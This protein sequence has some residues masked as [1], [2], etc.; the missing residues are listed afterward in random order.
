MKNMR[1]V[2]SLSLLAL[3]LFGAYELISTIRIRKKG[4]R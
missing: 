1:K 3:M 2:T 4:N